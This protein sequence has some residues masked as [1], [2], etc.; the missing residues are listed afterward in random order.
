M[1]KWQISDQNH[2]LTPLEKSQFF[3]FLN[4]FFFQP[5]KALFFFKYRR[6]HFPCLYCLKKRL[7][8][9]GFLDQNHG[10]T[11]LEKCQFFDFLNFFFYN[12][13]SGCFVVEYRRRQFP[14]LYCL[15][16]N[17]KN[18][19]FWTKIMGQPVL[20]NL[21]FSTFLISC[22]HRLERRFCARIS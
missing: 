22:C 7:K 8:N 3:D 11:S 4:F 2:G 9:C 18:G 19:R 14:G 17:W 6:R 16:K 13:E 10:L 21:N 15:K 20:K 12:L 1:E 5:R